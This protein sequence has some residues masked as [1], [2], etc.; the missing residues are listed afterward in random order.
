M[1]NSNL[2]SKFENKFMQIIYK[3]NLLTF[4]TLFEPNVLIK[5][6][7]AILFLYC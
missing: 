3:L 7:L 2:Y 1:K 6:T 4:S 5:M